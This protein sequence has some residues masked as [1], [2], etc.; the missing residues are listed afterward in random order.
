MEH[1][2][3]PEWQPYLVVAAAGAVFILFG[4]IF[5]MVQLVISVRRRAEYRDWVGDPWDGLTL[6]WLTSSPP[7]LYNF[8]VIPEVRS[9]DA[10]LHMK[11]RGIA[12]QR[13]ARY[14]DIAMPKNSA[15]GAVTGGLAFVFGFA[16]VWHMWWLA[17][18]SVLLIALTLI[19]RSS[20]DDTE[21]LLPAS[22]VEKIETRRF[23]EM[24]RAPRPDATQDASAIPGAA[25]PGRAS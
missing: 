19:F 3:T 24:A 15:F 2:D 20:D 14:E 25:L 16:M 18:L 11:E 12:Y 13:P 17:V 23:Q 4:L 7:A 9:R 5:M 10:F 1:Y 8:A 22:E 21:Y 6:E